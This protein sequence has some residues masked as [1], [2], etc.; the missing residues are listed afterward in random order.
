MPLVVV[1]LLLAFALFV[2]A[3]DTY[4]N[5]PSRDFAFGAFAVVLALEGLLA[6]TTVVLLSCYSPANEAHV[7]TLPA[8][9]A[10]LVTHVHVMLMV[11][12]AHSGH[13]DRCREAKGTSTIAM[14][15]P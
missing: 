8:R 13:T 6:L 7:P 9:R 14:I 5:A 15:S 1:M 12:A 4:A 2:Y 11:L 3:G 10:A